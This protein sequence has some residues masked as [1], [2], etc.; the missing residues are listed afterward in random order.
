MNNLTIDDIHKIREDHAIST[1][2]MSFDEYK[3]D[4]HK[5]IKPLLNLLKSMKPER[6]FFPSFQ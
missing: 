5:E 1:R 4:L 3:T 2:N 6:V